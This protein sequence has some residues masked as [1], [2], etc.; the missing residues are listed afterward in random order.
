MI[1][2]AC[3]NLLRV[4]QLFMDPVWVLYIPGLCLS[5]TYRMIHSLILFGLYIF[6][7]Y[8]FHLSRMIHSLNL[9]R[10]FSNQHK[11]YKDM[12]VRACITDAVLL[13]H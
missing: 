10:W 7:G 8:A 3:Q 1:S 13:R 11:A 9:G 2:S 4:L 6:E 5:P 12:V